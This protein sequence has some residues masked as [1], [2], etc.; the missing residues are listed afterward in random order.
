ML[1]VSPTPTAAGQTAGATWRPTAGSGTTAKGSPSSGDGLTTGR[2]LIFQFA[3]ARDEVIAAASDF[4]AGYPVDNEL[5]RSGFDSRGRALGLQSAWM[6]TREIIDKI[7]LTRAGVLSLQ[8]LG[9]RAVH[10]MLFAMTIGC[11]R[12]PGDISGACLGPGPEARP[13]SWLPPTL[14]AD[15]HCPRRFMGRTLRIQARPYAGAASIA[16]PEAPWWAGGQA[17][18]WHRSSLKVKKGGMMKT[19]I[20]QW[21]GRWRERRL[22]REQTRQTPAA[23]QAKRAGQA[24]RSHT[25]GQGG[26]GGG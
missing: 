25:M 4:T 15:C 24:G 23:R 6:I 20:S 12:R 21:V 1:M 19:R 26:S 7:P 5:G 17:Q 11:S 13:S 10:R 3:I 9:F 18:G 22:V 16:E 8:E 2:A 14:R